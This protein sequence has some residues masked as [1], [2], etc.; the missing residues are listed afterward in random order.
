MIFAT[1]HRKKRKNSTPGTHN[2]NPMKRL[3]ILQLS[4][5]AEAEGVDEGEKLCHDRTPGLA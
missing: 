3:P 1:R 2:G 5:S 4:P